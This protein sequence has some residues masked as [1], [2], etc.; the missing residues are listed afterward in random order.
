MHTLVVG[1]LRPPE[2]AAS[3]EFRDAI[4]DYD[5]DELAEHL[6]IGTLR[7][8]TVTDTMIADFRLMIEEVADGLEI[9][10]RVYE[11]QTHEFNGHTLDTMGKKRRRDFLEND[12]LA[13]LN[14]TP[15]QCA[16]MIEGAQIN[17]RQR[18]AAAFSRPSELL[19]TGR[20]LTAKKMP[21]LGIREGET[22][23]AIMRAFPLHLSPNEDQRAVD[24]QASKEVLK[25]AL[26]YPLPAPAERHRKAPAFVHTGHFS[27]LYIPDDPSE[28]N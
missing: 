20:Y 10:I 19:D 9:P 14:P 6:K 12:L 11:Y 21:L 5:G 7:F 3:V 25:K 1:I 24:T 2:T 16:L 23:G 4:I 27:K 26:C 13:S 17:P 28:K 22:R 8:D 15:S 18:V